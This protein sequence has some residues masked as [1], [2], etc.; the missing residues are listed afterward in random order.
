MFLQGTKLEA[1][2]YG[3]RTISFNSLLG[4]G[5][6]YDF[7]RVGYAPTY[8]DRLRYS[9]R[10][11]ADYYVVLSPQTMVNALQRT[12]YIAQCPG[13]FMKTEDVYDQ[14]ESIFASI[15]HTPIFKIV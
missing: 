8:V 6:A 11:C 13:T 9:F 5:E 1:V 3:D 15:S 7:M 12:I 2:A 14:N 10:L 4:L